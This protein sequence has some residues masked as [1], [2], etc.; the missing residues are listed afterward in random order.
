[1]S[2]LPNMFRTCLLA[3]SLALM[4]SS[5]SAQ[6]SGQP[7]AGLVCGNPNASTGFPLFT[8]QTLLLDRGFSSTQGNILNRGASVWSATPTPSLGRNG[9]TGGSLTL[10]GS[11]S[12]SAVISVAAGAGTTNFRLPIGNGTLNQVLVTDG[13][14]NTSWTTA[15]AGTV[16]SVGLSLPAI[17]SV[18]GSPV[19]G[20]GTLTATLATQLANLVWAGPTTGA[21]SAP[22]FRALV[23][24]DLPNPGASSLGGI[25]SFAAVS[26]QWIRQISTSGVPTASQPAFTDISGVLAAA[27]CPNPGASSL[28]CTQSFAAVTSQWIRQISTAGVVTASQPAFSDISGNATLAQL[29]SIGNNTIVSNISGG[30]AVPSGNTLTSLIDTIGATQG[31]VLYRNGSIWTVLAPGTAGFVLTT[32]GPAANPSWTNPAGGGTVTSLSSGTGVTV[33]GSP[34]T[35]ICSFSLAAIADHTVLANISG[36]SAAPISNTVTALLDNA[37]GSTQGNIL[38]RNATVW[39]VLAPGTNGQVLTQGASTPSWA[40]AG[41]VS[42]VTIVAGT[43]LSS[44]GTCNISTTG[45]CTLANLLVPTAGPYITSVTQ[46]SGSGGIASGR[47]YA[48]VSISTAAGNRYIVVT[49]GFRSTPNCPLASM[50][51]GGIAASRVAQQITSVTNTTITSIWIANVPTGTTATI[52]TTYCG[53]VDSAEALGVYALYGLSTGFIDSAG[54]SAAQV[55]KMTVAVPPGGYVISAAWALGQTSSITQLGALADFALLS[56][57]TSS[58]QY[59]YGASGVNGALAQIMNVGAIYGASCGSNECSALAASFK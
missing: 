7:T 53:S 43:G 24:A 27:Q 38:Y 5:A 18:S 45:T 46:T 26:S 11:T 39:T 41:S 48:G 10:N 19:T 20:A 29:P 40:S 54:S 3:L 55:N 9:G 37:L 57:P 33:S 47:S 16:S 44:S 51:I 36:G 21:A 17:F 52:V 31:Q 25:Q 58:S 14:G 49:N 56:D 4:A 50:T 12:G 2:Q 8:T 32:G 35:T 13:S 22:T 34:C 1:M 59:F 6:C 23:G 42:N 15:G 30:T 28:G